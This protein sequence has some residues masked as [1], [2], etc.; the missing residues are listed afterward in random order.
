MTL[1][2]LEEGIFVDAT[3]LEKIRKLDAIIFDCDGVLIDVYNSYD[4]AI[5]KTTDFVVK[6]MASINES[7]LVTSKM[8]DGFKS[9]GGFND[10]VD[11]TYVLILSV[12]AA[13]KI[14]KQFK[15][16]VFEVIKNADQDGIKSV[17]RFLDTLK[18]GISDI[19]KR[20]AYPGKRFEN[21]LSSIFDEMFYGTKL[22]A[23]LYKNKPKF[24]DGRGLIDNDVVLLTKELVDELQ[25]RFDK[26]IAIVTGRGLLSAQYSLKKLFDEFDIKNSRFLEDES[27]EMAKPN[28]QSL[29][30]SITG[31]GAT[32]TVF[33]GDSTEDYIMAREAD[34]VG[35]S[36]IF[37]GV[38]GTSKDPRA[39]RALFENKNADIIVESINLIP[40]TLNLVGA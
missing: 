31:M 2:K 23:K 32:C 22:Y 5:K 21:P 38:Y 27:R 8:I 35:K 9:T 16:F 29:I 14:S 10:E 25:K 6:E 7:N 28:P 3:K 18:V 17:E 37:C 11:L 19:R 26:K 1:K 39:K 40:K 12:V 24:F 33:V 36:T 34:D 4:L 15:E 30:S 13:N 20:L